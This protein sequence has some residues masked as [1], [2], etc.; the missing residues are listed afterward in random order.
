MTIS[1]NSLNMVILVRVT[2]IAILA[3]NLSNQEKEATYEIE[4]HCSLHGN[5][6]F[7]FW[8]HSLLTS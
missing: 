4:K 1:V 6:R 5:P 2:E 8:P 7:Y 3:G